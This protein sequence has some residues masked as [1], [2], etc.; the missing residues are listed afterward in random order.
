MQRCVYKFC[1]IDFSHAAN[2]FISLLMKMYL[3]NSKIDLWGKVWE[4][5]E[6]G[7]SWGDCPWLQLKETLWDFWEMHVQWGETA[8]ES[9]NACGVLCQDS[10]MCLQVSAMLSARGDPKISNPE[11]EAASIGPKPSFSR[12]QLSEYWSKGKLAG[13][14]RLCHGRIPTSSVIQ[15]ERHSKQRWGKPHLPIQTQL[16]SWGQCF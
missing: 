6:M 15:S 11:I 14:N 12:A 4:G 5:R 7:L 8:S 13:E 3:G 1:I 10:L 9:R 16:G 2:T